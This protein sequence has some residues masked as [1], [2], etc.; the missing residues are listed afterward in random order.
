MRKNS[1]KKVAGKILSARNVSL[2]YGPHLILDE[3]SFD[4]QAGDKIGLVGPNGCGKS[5]LLK[6]L[7]NQLEA[8]KGE[9]VLFPNISVGFQPQ[10][11]GGDITGL[12]YLGEILNSAEID[13]SPLYGLGLSEAILKKK[14][15]EM[16][17][18][19]RSKIV[20]AKIMSL[21]DD[22][23]LLDE[24]TNNLDHVALKKLEKHIKD[25]KATFIIVSHDRKLLTDLT[26][27]IFEIDSEKRSLSVYVGNFEDYL[28]EKNRLKYKQ[29]EKWQDFLD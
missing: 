13:S 10:E 24:P 7:A 26:N 22:L 12:G 14:F 19:E 17:G 3:V 2:S 23:I 5:S 20:L 28:E 9:M 29:A 27:K 4:V 18:G 21:R 1:N 6:L 11:I 8:D 25:S 15:D 16:S